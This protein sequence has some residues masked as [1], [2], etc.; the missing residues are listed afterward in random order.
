MLLPALIFAVHEAVSGD[1]QILAG[2]IAVLAT[3]G[4]VVSGTRGAWV[5]AGV[6]VLLFMVPQLPARR[7]LPAVAGI[8]ILLLAVCQV[9][10]VGDLVAERSG[11][12]VETGGAG[13]T[14]IW[15]VGLHIFGSAPVT[16]SVSPTSL[17]HT[18]WMPFGP[19]V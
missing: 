1:R 6:G 4:I 11:N 14:D 18:P 10:G 8:L 9:P 7:R 3:I 13:R 5:A 17:S 19:L 2:R 12:A 16:G 15:S